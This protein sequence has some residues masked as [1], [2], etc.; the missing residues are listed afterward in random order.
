[1]RMASEVQP[2][3]RIDF[4]MAGLEA[5]CRKWNVRKLAIFGSAVRDD[6]SERSDVDFLYLFDPGETPGWA[7]ESLR[8]ELSQLVGGRKADLVAWRHILPAIRERVLGEAVVV[9]ERQ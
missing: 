4:A 6:F 2:A 3:L 1:M 8:R 5:I 7:L 9:Y